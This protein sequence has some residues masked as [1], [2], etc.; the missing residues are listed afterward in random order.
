MKKK[1]IIFGLV[2]VL[3]A[4]NGT[5]QALHQ[6][7]LEVCSRHPAPFYVACVFALIILMTLPPLE[8]HGQIETRHVM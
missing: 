3:M 6:I 5:A 8:M 4:L 7:F 1:L 2:C